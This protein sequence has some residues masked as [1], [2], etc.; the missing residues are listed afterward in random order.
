MTRL[1][2][3]QED[4]EFALYMNEMLVCRDKSIDTVAKFLIEV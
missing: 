2:G 4:G 3:L 1:V